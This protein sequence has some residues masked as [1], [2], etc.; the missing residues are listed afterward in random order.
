MRY[1]ILSILLCGGAFLSALPV[2]AM[3]ITTGDL[4]KSPETSDVYYVGANGKRYAFPNEKTY[5]SW[6]TGFNVKTI[7]TTDVANIPFGGVATYRPGVWMLKLTTDPKTYAVDQGGVLRW[8][9]T[10]DVAVALYGS[11]W[12]TKIQDVP[13]TFFTTYSLGEP[14][15]SIQDFNPIAKQNET[16]SISVDKTLVTPEP[17]PVVPPV[18]TVGTISLVSS[19]ATLQAGDVPLFIASASHPTGILKVELFFDEI[20]IKTCM[21]ST[22]SDETVIPLSGTKSEYVVTAIATALDNSTV[23]KSITLSVTTDSSSLTRISIGR[24]HL[25]QNQLAEIVIDADISVAVLRTDIYAN[26]LSIEACASAIRQCRWSGVLSGDVGT[27]YTVYGIVKDTLGRTYKSPEKTITISDNDSPSV[28]ISVGKNLIYT[29]ET[30]DVTINASDDDGMSTMTLL[31]DGATVAVCVNS[32]SCTTFAGP[33][34]EIGTHQ[35]SAIAEDAL[36]GTEITD[37]VTVTVQALPN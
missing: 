3:E 21:G 11:N 1:R 17:P 30:I 37:P 13:D 23:E 20:L 18:E 12:A 8:I 24:S 31:Q 32:F 2:H 29:G 22:C 28:T 6:Y 10:E 5:F 15:N 14:I 36:G 34:S 16:T 4:I 26:G 19:I 35:F 25:R 9:T 27:V 33:W 7:S